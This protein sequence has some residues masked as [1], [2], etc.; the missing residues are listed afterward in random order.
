MQHND[1]R[2][3]TAQVPGIIQFGRQSNTSSFGRPLHAAHHQVCVPPVHLSASAPS[4]PTHQHHQ[5]RLRDG[6]DDGGDD[7]ASDASSDWPDDGGDD[8][9]DGNSDWSGGSD[10]ASDASSDWPDDGGDDASDGNSDWS[11]GSDDDDS[12]LSDASDGDCDWSGG[13]DDER[14]LLSDASD[15]DSEDSED[16]KALVD[17][18]YERRNASGQS[19]IFCD[20]PASHIY[21]PTGNDVCV[22]IC[23]G[24]DCQDEFHSNVDEQFAGKM[25]Y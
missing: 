20:H 4:A 24:S 3:E 5:K 17:Q 6:K 8:A 19:C 22:C 15:G 25:S 16:A 10:D 23:N 21:V 12:L 13:S 18:N 11:G 1:G 14:S 9:S 7:D 2:H